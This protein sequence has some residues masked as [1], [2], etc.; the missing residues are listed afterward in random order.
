MLTTRYLSFNRAQEL[1]RDEA[2]YGRDTQYK[3]E[4]YQDIVQNNGTTVAAP[5]SGPSVDDRA[6]YSKNTLHAQLGIGP[7]DPPNPTLRLPLDDRFNEH[8]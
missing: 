5:V 3:P 6:T 8:R 7:G 2:H 1:T 4:W